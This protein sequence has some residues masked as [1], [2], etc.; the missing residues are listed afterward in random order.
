[1]ESEHWPGGR[2]LALVHVRGRDG[3]VGGRQHDG[4]VRLGQH[5]G[6]ARQVVLPVVR[7]E[8][9]ARR[10]PR[11]ARVQVVLSFLYTQPTIDNYSKYSLDFL[12]PIKTAEAFEAVDRLADLPQR[13]WPQAAGRR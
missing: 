4:A 9:T 10:K 11:V 2:A 6:A 1:V 13:T 7:D 8:L 12:R 3:G 5:H